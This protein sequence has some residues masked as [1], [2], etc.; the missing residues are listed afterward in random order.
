[1]R[2]HGDERDIDRRRNHVALLQDREEWAKYRRLPPADLTWPTCL[3]IAPS[4]VVHN[5]ERELSVVSA[6]VVPVSRL[7]EG[8]C[9]GVTSK[10]GYIQGLLKK[11]RR[12]C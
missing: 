3:I 9:S 11:E 2:K 6:K 8:F 4:S 5:W 1:M 12:S 10:L 7:A